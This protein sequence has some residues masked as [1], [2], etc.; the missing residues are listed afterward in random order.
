VTDRQPDRE[1]DAED[2][3]IDA[4]LTVQRWRR[5]APWQLV[6]LHHVRHHVAR[7]M[8][9]VPAWDAIEAAIVRRLLAAD[10]AGFTWNISRETQPL[11]E[12]A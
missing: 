6:N 11:G 7:E 1:Y 8:R 12:M 2:A 9:C 4:A 3:L 5:M 10:G